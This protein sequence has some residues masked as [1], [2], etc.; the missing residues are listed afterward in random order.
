MKHP[1]SFLAGFATGAVTMYYLDS[2]SGGRRRALVRDKMVSAGHDVADF[3]QAKARRAMDRAKGVLATGDLHGVTHRPPQSDQQLHDRIR[4]RLGHVISHPKA[5]LVLVQ[6]GR[7]RL[8]GHV[9]RP[10]V[11]ALLSAVRR[12]PGVAE[13]RDELEVHDSPDGVPHLQGNSEPPSG[14]P[15]ALH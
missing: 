8:Q 10:E 7:V 13:L 1:L 3:A 12:M 9:L 5:V 6:D 14:T 4:A 2:T 15:T 11:D